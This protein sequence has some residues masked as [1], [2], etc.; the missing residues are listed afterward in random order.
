MGESHFFFAEE[1]IHF[2]LI[3]W[4]RFLI[5]SRII[6]DYQTRPLMSQKINYNL[7]LTASFAFPLNIFSFVFSVVRFLF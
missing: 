4:M 5:I 2:Y 1:E 3:Y 6:K 7:Q